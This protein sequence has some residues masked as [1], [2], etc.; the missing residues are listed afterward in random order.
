MGLLLMVALVITGGSAT[1]ALERSTPRGIVLG[2]ASN[3]TAGDVLSQTNQQR[4]DVGLDPLSSSDRL[5]LAAFAKAEDMFAK[6][7]WAHVS[8]DG[9]PPWDFIRN[10][11]YRYSIAG[12]NLARDFDSTAPMVGAWMASPTHRDNIL[13]PR[14]TET[15][16]AVV[17]GRL[18][19]VETTL[20]VQMFGTPIMA[21]PTTDSQTTTTQTTPEAVVEEVPVQVQESLLDG[22]SPPVFV[23]DSPTVLSQTEVGNDPAPIYI[24]PLDIRKSIV[25][26]VILLIMVVLVVDEVIIR[27][28]KTA[29]FVGRNLAHMSFL[30]LVALIVLNIIQP[31]SIQ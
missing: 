2:Y 16:I 27:H 6:D 21:A 13:H 17:N 4:V 31:G 25:L 19:G 3:I 30:I 26:A 7:Y 1:R 24:S 14:Y 18:Q 8:P 20:V 15:G 12:E 29:R 5:N 9:V 11:G 10:T 22:D 28:R 23:M